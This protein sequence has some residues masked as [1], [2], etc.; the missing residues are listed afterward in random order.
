[1]IPRRSGG[2]TLV[3]LL[4]V[5]VLLGL[6]ASLLVPRLTGNRRQAELRSARHAIEESLRLA[7]LRAQTRHRAVWLA[8]EIGGNQMWLEDG[9]Q[10]NPPRR[11]L[12][13]VVVADARMQS[14]TTQRVSLFRVRCGP[15]G[16]AIPWAVELQA[17]DQRIIAWNDGIGGTLSEVI[18]ERLAAFLWGAEPG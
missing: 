10:P 8:F 4:V 12:T 13:G 11:V 7:Q 9:T 3:E 6:A 17:G 5:V 1:M 15:S 14:G 16:T 2:F 18:G